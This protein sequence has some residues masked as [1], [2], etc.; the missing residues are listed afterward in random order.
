MKLRNMV[1]CVLAAGFAGAAT[2]VAGID[3]VQADPD[4]ELKVNSNKMDEIATVEVAGKYEEGRYSRVATSTLTYVVAVRGGWSYG[5]T[6]SQLPF[7]LWISPWMGGHV[8]PE[9]LQEDWVKYAI[10][11]SYHDPMFAGAVNQKISPVE[12][13]NDKL[14]QLNGNARESFMKQGHT[15]VYAQAY[16]IVAVE[17]NHTIITDPTSDY[18]ASIKVPA[19]IVCQPLEAAPPATRNPTTPLFSTVSLRTEATQ[20]VQMGKFICPSK[21]KLYGRVEATRKFQG[22]ALFVG[23]YYISNITPLNFPGKG[24][25]N[26]TGTYTMNWEQ[27]GGLTTAPNTEPKKQKFTFRFNIADSGGELWG[28][29]E[30]TIEVSCRKIKVNAPTA[31]DGM[32]VN[33]AN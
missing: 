14:E 24:A 16:E 30:K 28:S 3:Q 19:R 9:K 11:R 12:L 23:P 10:N 17:W 18:Y 33:P 31:G 20:I 8:Y 29:A 25:R 27:K 15:F 22:K 26:V 6:G 2:M 5:G 32:T 1:A 13:C 4:I 7:E 21:I